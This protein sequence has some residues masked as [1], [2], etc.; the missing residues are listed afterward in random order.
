ME[1]NLSP[2]TVEVTV[3]F[4]VSVAALENDRSLTVKDYFHHE[5]RDALT[6]DIP[7]MNELL[8]D[9]GLPIQVL[10]TRSQ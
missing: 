10:S 5:I 4:S 2:E 6:P 1:E 7:L 8:A 9:A 3:S